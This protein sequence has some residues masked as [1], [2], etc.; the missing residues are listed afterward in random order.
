MKKI[1]L[2]LI[3]VFFV[4]CS[5]TRIEYVPLKCSVSLPIKPNCRDYEIEYECLK[6]KGRYLNSLETA[7]QKCI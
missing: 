7:L 5:S 1:A 6:A 2:L 3:S 4:A